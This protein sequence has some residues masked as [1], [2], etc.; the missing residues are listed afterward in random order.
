M[1]RYVFDASKMLWADRSSSALNPASDC[2]AIRPSS[3]GSYMSMWEGPMKIVDHR[4]GIQ[5]PHCGQ[6]G[7]F[8]FSNIWQPAFRRAVAATL[9][10]GAG[11]LFCHA[12]VRE[13]KAPRGFQAFHIPVCPDEPRR[14]LEPAFAGSHNGGQSGGPH[15]AATRAGLYAHPLSALF[16][17]RRSR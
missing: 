7:G 11:R 3:F 15:R 5:M 17:A 14:K 13:I 6:V 4:S 1:V 12:I 10:T 8:R 16:Q 2:W 9:L